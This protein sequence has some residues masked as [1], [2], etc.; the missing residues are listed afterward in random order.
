MLVAG[1]RQTATT[2]RAV[3]LTLFQPRRDRFRL[4]RHRQMKPQRNATDG[5]WRKRRIIGRI[6]RTV[7][8]YGSVLSVPF[9]DFRSKNTTKDEPSSKPGCE[10]PFTLFRP[11]CGRFRFF[12]H[13]H[14]TPTRSPRARVGGKS[15]NRPRIPWDG[16]VGPAHSV[17]SV[18]FRHFRS[19]N[20]TKDEPSTRS[21]SA[22]GGGRGRRGRGAPKARSSAP[23]RPATPSPCRLYPSAP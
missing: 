11:K 18:P 20:T 16:S 23:A 7:R 17:P 6:L 2:I 13:R 9:R 10:V 12:A 8:R 4:F 5:G 3:P 15:Y 1:Q 19:K 14:R 21:S 22:S